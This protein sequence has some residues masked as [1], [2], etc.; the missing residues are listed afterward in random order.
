VTLALENVG[1]RAGAATLLADASVTVT[2][3]EVFVLL[4]PNGA[5]KSTLFSVASG[6]R[7]DHAGRALL[8]GRP[9]AR[10][11]ADALA[12]RRAV[13][14][15]KTTVAFPFRVHEVVMLGRAP[16]R[17]F[18][19]ARDDA[20]AVDASM[21][22]A[23]VAHLAERLYT[24]LSGGEQ[25]RVQLARALAQV[26]GGAEPAA[27]FLLLD[28][29]TASLD[30]RHQAALLGIVRD[31]A[32]GG[33]GVL[34]ILHDLNLAAAIADRIALMRAGRV[35]ATGTPCEVVTRERIE[36]VYEVAARVE[37]D[38]LTGRP[39]VWAELGSAAVPADE[40]TR[41]A[42]VPVARGASRG[43]AAIGPSPARRG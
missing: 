17:G 35:V 14:A 26:W 38:P 1:V 19:S 20:S 30:L 28:E 5:G 6:V 40:A 21:A 23:D 31:F 13:M 12:R 7:R 39:R 32:E 22:R 36:S 24:T 25:Q 9:L 8:D 16:H 4:G 3:G 18:A 34:M 10:W 37:R 2:P 43:P 33:G 41:R 42:A 29:P 15:Q 27:R 11:P